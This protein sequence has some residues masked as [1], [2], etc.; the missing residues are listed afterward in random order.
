MIRLNT[1]L[2]GDLHRRPWHLQGWR[3]FFFSWK[4]LSGAAP[5][6]S[7]HEPNITVKIFPLTKK[8]CFCRA[9][10]GVDCSL[11][12]HISQGAGC[13][14][15]LLV[16]LKLLAIPFFFSSPPL[17]SSSSALFTMHP[18]AP[19]VVIVV[20]VVNAYWLIHDYRVRKK[21]SLSYIRLLMHF[22]SR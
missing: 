7:C 20:F 22:H 3:S 16:S 13:W 15:S 10:S 1:R 14:L 8:M 11:I 12:A 17:P 2:H 18:V 9:Q 4:V 5:Q 6:S 21:S 19:I